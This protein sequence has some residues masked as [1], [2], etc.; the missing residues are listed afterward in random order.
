[1]H[2]D[3][4]RTF[5][6]VVATGNFNRAAEN[7]NVTQSTVSARIRSLEDELGRALFE[8]G[9]NG[10]RLTAAGDRLL[11]HGHSMR[12]LWQRARN[13][14]ALPDAYD[15]S[16]SLGVT[17]SLWEEIELPWV[18]WMHREASTVSLHVEADYS[19]GLMRHLRDGILDIA[20]M[21][22]PLQMQELVIEE[23]L[24]D[25]LVLFTTHPA[26]EVADEIWRQNYVLVDW[27][28]DFRYDHDSMYPDLVHS[29]SAGLSSVAVQYM[30]RNAASAYLPA[31]LVLRQLKKGLVRP[32]R[33]APV[34]E[35]TGCLIY[36]KSPADGNLLNLGLEGL[37][38][39]TAELEA[40]TARLVE[41]SR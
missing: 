28:E 10:A 14:V 26:C 8:R 37:R 15:S 38:S 5:L 27:G 23:F 9:R 21:Y 4:I 22:E 18:N 12:R 17:L 32:V 31:R 29:F 36:S 19:P 13:D 24:R 34:F 2:I 33:N 39:V 35:R 11:R 30:E 40:Q 41:A 1:M 25:E 6:E 7:L 3:Q 16:L 20:V